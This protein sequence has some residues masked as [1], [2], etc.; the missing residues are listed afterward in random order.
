MSQNRMM[1]A[2]NRQNANLAAAEVRE[3]H[4][5]SRCHELLD[6]FYFIACGSPV[7]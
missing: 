6:G 4:K 3:K 1:K 2:K 5:K 7:L